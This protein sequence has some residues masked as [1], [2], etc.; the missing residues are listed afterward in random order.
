LIQQNIL[1]AKNLS[2]YYQ[3]TKILAL[4]VCAVQTVSGIHHTLEALL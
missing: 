4:A 1:G 2:E 3:H